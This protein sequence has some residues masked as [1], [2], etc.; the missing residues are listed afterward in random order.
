ME[1]API[2][3]IPEKHVKTLIIGNSGIG[4]TATISKY[5][6]DKFPEDFQSTLGMDFQLKSLARNGQ[7]IRLQIWVS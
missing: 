7:N 4:K 2:D 6:E 5:I 1:N 3:I